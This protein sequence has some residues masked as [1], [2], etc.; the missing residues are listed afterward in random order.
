MTE[1]FNNQIAC[2]IT[3]N[4][5]LPQ[6]RHYHFTNSLLLPT[7]N[8][9]L[10]M[11]ANPDII[12]PTTPDDTDD[13]TSGDPDATRSNTTKKQRE[14]AINKIIRASKPTVAKAEAKKRRVERDAKIAEAASDA[15]IYEQA[16]KIDKSTHKM[17][18]NANQGKSDEV[19]YHPTD[20]TKAKKGKERGEDHPITRKHRNRVKGN[21]NQRNRDHGDHD[22]IMRHGRDERD[23]ADH[24]L[25]PDTRE[26][27][28]LNGYSGI[29]KKTGASAGASAGGG[30]GGGGG[31][32][33]GATKSK[34]ELRAD[35]A[36]KRLSSGGSRRR[37]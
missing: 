5:N 35:A 10:G 34:A 37:R 13:Q 3:K 36:E 12:D 22:D 20:K 9:L 24:R 17:Y 14:Q 23:P 7:D 30:G 1:V 25:P 18:S 28:K 21:I 27:S 4:R 29:A 16:R 8:Q 15:R 6:R 33:G 31:S 32:G 19:R 2:L 11:I 26:V